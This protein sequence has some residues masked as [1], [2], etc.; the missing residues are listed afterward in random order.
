M[1]WM[2]GGATRQRDRAVRR[3]SVVA[4][5]VAFVERP[6]SELHFKQEVGPAGFVHCGARERYRV[7]PN[8]AS[9]PDVL[10]ANPY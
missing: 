4:A 1:K 9:W 6:A 2:S 7:G 8:V 10:T 5:L 3:T